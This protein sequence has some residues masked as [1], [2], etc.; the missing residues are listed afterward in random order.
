MSAE[1]IYREVH[2]V[3]ITKVPG[4]PGTFHVY[5]LNKKEYFYP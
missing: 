5:F 3:L 1:N 2:I 4:L